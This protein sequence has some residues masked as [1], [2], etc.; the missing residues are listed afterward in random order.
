MADI[1]AITS[2]N[3][4][5]TPNASSTSD[6]VPQKT[7]GQDDFLKLLV[8]QFTNQD[9]MQPMKDTEYIAQMAQFTSLEQAKSMTS[10]TQFTQAN[11]LIGRTVDLLPTG[12]ETPITGVVSSV[13]VKAGTPQ[14]V[15]DDQPY[16]LS[17]ELNIR[18]TPQPTQSH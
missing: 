1:S 10:S 4:A 5:Y 17:S 2:T 14:I 18:P 11:G 9:P 8:T 12:Q 3:A 15:V 16:D 7:L 13:N 6:R